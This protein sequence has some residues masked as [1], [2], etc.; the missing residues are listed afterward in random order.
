M[1]IKTFKEYGRSRQTK[2]Y[3][4]NNLPF[5]ACSEDEHEKCELLGTAMA[6]GELMGTYDCGCPCHE[7]GVVPIG[8]V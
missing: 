8:R 1:T 3:N 5:K 2:K 4:P 6:Q 7:T